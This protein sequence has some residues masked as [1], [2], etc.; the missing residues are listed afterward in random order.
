VFHEA[1]AAWAARRGRTG[2]QSWRR[3]Y[4]RFLPWEA[5]YA[6]LVYEGGPSDDALAAARWCVPDA[7]PRQI[8]AVVD[9]FES[10]PDGDE[11]TVCL[12]EVGWARFTGPADDAAL[13]TLPSVLALDPDVEIV[14]YRPERRCTFRTR[15]AQVRYGKVF[16]DTAGAQLHEDAQ[17]LYRASAR[18]EL[19][20]SVAEPVAWDAERRVLWQRAVS[21]EPLLERLSGP[22]AAA[23]AGRMGEAAGTLVA[24]TVVPAARFDAPVQCARSRS[25]A[26]ELGVRVPALAKEAAGLGE[27]LDALHRQRPGRARPIHGAPHV[28]QWLLHGDRL[29]LVDFDRMSIGNPELD[30]ATFLGELDF[31]EELT[32]PVETIARSFIDGYERTAGPLDP[33]LLAAYRA[34]KRLAKAL[35]SARALRPDGALRAIRHFATARA[36]WA[37][38]E[39]V[40]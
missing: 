26:R 21:G 37:A 11:Q 35:R 19:G 33:A 18:G 27:D 38:I 29:A 30:V 4:G 24:S 36:A 6:R 28:N 2:A 34:H 25:Y 10:R 3:V 39:D 16:P 14:R 22:G 9:L 32:T 23:L 5:P 8:F 13:T 7:A 31:E 40:P 20:F 1:L 12:P 17:G 15:G